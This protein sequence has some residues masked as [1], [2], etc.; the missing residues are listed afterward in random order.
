MRS[1]LA[2]RGRR[3]GLACAS[4][5]WPRG[6]RACL[7][8]LRQPSN[9]KKQNKKQNKT[10][11]SLTLRMPC[12]GVLLAKVRS[13]TDAGADHGGSAEGRHSGERERRRASGRTA[14]ALACPCA[15]W[16]LCVCVFRIHDTTACP[17][18]SCCMCVSDPLHDCGP[19]PHSAATASPCMCGERVRMCGCTAQAMER[20]LGSYGRDLVSA[21]GAEVDRIESEIQ[22]LNPGGDDF[23]DDKAAASW[24]CGS[25]KL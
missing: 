8:P 20:L 11:H 25:V 7:L 1:R 3:R 17:C 16:C 12:P 19:T 9:T 10:A 13:R 5:R 14:R 6:L 24:C 4:S 23:D 2:W 22:R 21:V 18:A 15:S